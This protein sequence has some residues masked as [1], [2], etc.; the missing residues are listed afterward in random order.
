MSLGF[1]GPINTMVEYALSR[2]YRI[3]SAQ[4]N[5][6]RCRCKMCG[7]ELPKEHG[8]QVYIV[9]SVLSRPHPYYF[10]YGCFQPVKDAWDRWPLEKEPRWWRELDKPA[11]VERNHARRQPLP[12]A[13]LDRLIAER[14]RKLR[15]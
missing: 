1:E 6:I 15:K 10:C 3:Q 11:P 14:E 7:R 8:F 13:E 5:A 2:V 9:G 12:D 4:R